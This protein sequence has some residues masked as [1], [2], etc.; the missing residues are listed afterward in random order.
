[1]MI[2]VNK[3]NDNN[4]TV[5]LGI[6]ENDEPFIDELKAKEAYSVIQNNIRSLGWFPNTHNKYMYYTCVYNNVCVYICS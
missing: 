2:I 3:I 1:M 6:Q 5:M 4:I